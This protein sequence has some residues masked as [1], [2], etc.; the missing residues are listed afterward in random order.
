MKVETLIILQ[1]IAHLLTDF[2]F[3]SDTNSIE[4]NELGFKS[5]FL[6]FHFL[7]AF[8]L[9][10]I[11]SFQIDFIMY[12]LIIGVIH[13]II[14]GIKK[15]LNKNPKVKTYIFFVDQLLHILV[16]LTVTLIYVTDYKIIKPLGIYIEFSWVL[17]IAGYLLIL[18][19]A[20]ILIR[21]VFNTFKINDQTTDDLEKAGRL[22]GSLERQ[23]TLTF[24]LLGQYEAVGFLI[25]GK[26]ILR[27]KEGD[28]RKTE[29]VLI[30]TM[31][32]FMIA[33]FVGI[34]II[35]LRTLS[36]V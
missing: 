9:S 21:Q 2:F 17:V 27:Y 28:T 13:I 36:N 32:S 5:K 6:P 18:K 12:A 24:V 23:L 25:A 16:F 11:L 31:L 29:Y 1:F 20:N 33:I 30:G 4:K 34:L 15:E 35:K 3:Q 14:D 7:I 26:S 22:I 19:P 10:W 8:I